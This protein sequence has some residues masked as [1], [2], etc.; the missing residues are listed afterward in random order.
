M[1]LPDWFLSFFV[2]L[3]MNVNPPK[4]MDRQRDIHLLANTLD[5][6]AVNQFPVNIAQ[7]APG[8][9]SGPGQKAALHATLGEAIQPIIKYS[10]ANG[11]FGETVEA[12]FTAILGAFIGGIQTA[13]GPGTV[14][15]FRGRVLAVAGTRIWMSAGWPEKNGRKATYREFTGLLLDGL[16]G[17][18]V[19]RVSALLTLYA[20]VPSINRNLTEAGGTNREVHDWAAALV[21]GLLFAALVSIGSLRNV[22]QQ[23]PPA[24]PGGEGEAAPAPAST[25][26]RPHLRPRQQARRPQAYSAIKTLVA[27]VRLGASSRQPGSLAPQATPGSLVLQLRRP[28]ARSRP[29][30]IARLRHSPSPR[31]NPHPRRLKPPAGPKPGS[32]RAQVCDFPPPPLAQSSEPPSTPAAVPT[33]GPASTPS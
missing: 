18:A 29:S 12:M 20:L 10:V 33:L 9:S 27:L 22:T 26:L 8:V 17:S 11:L 19:S 23:A 6:G 30:S 16:R 21:E 5:Y 15:N 25:A 3:S 13:V 1:V 4:S 32:A 31:P 2:R 24:R 7:V 14:N 28:R